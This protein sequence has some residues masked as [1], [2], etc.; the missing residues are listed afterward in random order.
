MKQQ[1]TED[2]GIN[3]LTRGISANDSDTATEAQIQQINQNINLAL[4]NKINSFGEKTFWKLR[5]IYYYFYFSKKDKK[6]I[7]INR[8]V[9]TMGDEISRDEIISPAEPNIQIINKSDAVAI[10][11]KQKADF[12]ALYPML[13]QDPM[14]PQV[15]KR[16]MTRK[17][18]KLTGQSRQE[19]ESY[20]PLMPDEMQAK[21]DVAFLNRNLPVNIQDM[22][23]DH[24]TYLVI[25]QSALDTPAKRA[26]ITARQQAY[27]LS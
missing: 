24:Y 23:E 18:L 4:G 11:M 9:E 6:Y 8:G 27:I 12:M 3:D 19:V 26:A 22:N 21:E 20:I 14:I 10:D 13:M 25:Y 16:F 7:Q 17:A 2:V 5:Y 15:G 1:T